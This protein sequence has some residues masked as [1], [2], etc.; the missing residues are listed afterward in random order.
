MLAPNIGA[1]LLEDDEV[2]STNSRT[3]ETKFK[4]KSYGVYVK[5]LY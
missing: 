3:F 5:L 4:V 1:V 2:V